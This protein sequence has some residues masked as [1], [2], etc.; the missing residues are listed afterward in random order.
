MAKKSPVKSG[1]KKKSAPKK[2]G[3]ATKK[4]ATKPK[5]EDK[6][7]AAGKK[8][9]SQT[10]KT[11]GAKRAVSPKELIMKKFERWKPDTLY[12]PSEDEAYLQGFSAPPM[13]AEDNRQTRDIL[14]RKFDFDFSRVAS[15]TPPKEKKAPPKAAKKAKPVSPKELI[16][17]KFEKW[18]PDTLYTPSEDEAYLQG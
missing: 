15:Q 11:A 18:K 7:K 5:S 10:K 9:Q 13:V 12:T 1:S 8:K 17:K 6:S 2:K 14:A 4:T 3:T 16:M